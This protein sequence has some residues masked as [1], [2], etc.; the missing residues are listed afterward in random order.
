[1]LR[2]ARA[3]RIWSP[4]Q[5]MVNWSIHNLLMSLWTAPLNT[6]VSLVFDIC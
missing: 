4:L 1:V 5:R 2:R 3:L 6:S